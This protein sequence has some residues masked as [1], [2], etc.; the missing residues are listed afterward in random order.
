MN[1]LQLL[2]SSPEKEKVPPLSS[3]HFSKIH[4]FF[5]INYCAVKNAEFFKLTLKFL[6]LLAN[7]MV[8]MKRCCKK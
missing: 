3:S 6:T 7:E 8:S 2:I 4:S 5:F 1:S